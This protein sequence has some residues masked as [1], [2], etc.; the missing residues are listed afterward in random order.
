MFCEV[1][2]E[3]GAYGQMLA[4]K[5]EDAFVP[6]C[7]VKQPDQDDLLCGYSFYS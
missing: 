1:Y 6:W 3:G 7:P 5:G 2:G 4:S